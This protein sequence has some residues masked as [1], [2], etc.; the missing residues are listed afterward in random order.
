MTE[1]SW[2][3]ILR[4]NIAFV[5]L[6]LWPESL[7]SSRNEFREKMAQYPRKSRRKEWKIKLQKD[8]RKNFS[9]RTTSQKQN[10]GDE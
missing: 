2:V 1:V 10:V 8:N 5:S 3:W 7:L 9:S 6:N 4:E